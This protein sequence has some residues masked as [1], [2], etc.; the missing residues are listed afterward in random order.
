MNDLPIA[1]SL[2]RPAFARRR[3]TVLARLLAQA[4]EHRITRRSLHFRCLPTRG[5]VV[6]L[7]AFVEDERLCCRS[8]DFHLEVRRA[9]GRVWLRITGP[10]GTRRFL[11]GLV[12]TTAV[13]ADLFE[14]GGH[15]AHG[16][17]RP[18]E[19]ESVYDRLRACASPGVGTGSAHCTRMPWH[20]RLDRRPREV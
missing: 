17:G 4:Q 5:I 8:L 18:R 14:R 3:R 6:E 9:A 19:H 13:V 11:Q 1:R 10:R 20:S 2:S 7:G 16:H 15:L 12:P